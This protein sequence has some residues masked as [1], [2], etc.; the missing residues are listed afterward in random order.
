MI[1]GSCG[2]GHF[3]LGTGNSK[4]CEEM[5]IEVRF[6]SAEFTVGDWASVVRGNWVYD[7]IA[8]PAHRLD[9]SLRARGGVAAR[10][11]PHGLVG[12]SFASAAPR[13]GLVDEYPASGTFRTTAMAEGAIEGIAADY[14]VPSPYS[15]NF[16]YARFG[17]RGMAAR[18]KTGLNVS[19]APRLTS[20]NST[21]TSAGATGNFHW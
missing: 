11:L 13:F 8:G 7:R 5:L 10:H 16:K 18:K 15:V 3:F 2:G 9:V 20:D 14:E 6:S 1:N 4:K 21:I 17:T 19:A 12:Q